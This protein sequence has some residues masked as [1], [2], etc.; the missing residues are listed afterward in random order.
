M[1]LLPDE[2]GSPTSRKEREKWGA[3]FSI[4]VVAEGA[5]PRDG[6]RIVMSEAYAGHS[7]R[8]GGVGR[9]V[10]ERLGELTGKETRD[11]VLGHLQRGGAPTSFDRT[12]ATRF[13]GK[14]VE[15][16]RAGDFGKMV[17]FDPPDIVAIPLQDV[18]GKLK[19][20]PLEFDLIRTARAIGVSFGE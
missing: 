19:R 14:A 20:V 13:G 18:V 12:L 16:L 15:L 7:E 1:E 8:L 17:A 4:I 2:G 10:A 3:R 6:K 9:Q 11:V 5:A